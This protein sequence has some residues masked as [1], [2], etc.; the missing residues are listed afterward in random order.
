MNRGVGLFSVARILRERNGFLRLRTGR[1]AYLFGTESA[2]KDVG[3]R[4]KK[5][6]RSDDYALLDDGTHVFF[7]GA[8]VTFFLR[9]WSEQAC[10]AVEGT[11]YSILLPVRG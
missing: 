7:D 3:Q 1:L 4:A 11:S 10:A 2:A 8:D 6:T 9:P 5:A